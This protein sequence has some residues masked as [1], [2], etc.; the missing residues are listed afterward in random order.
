MKKFRV[1]AAA[2][3]LFSLAFAVSAAAQNNGGGN[4]SGR[5]YYNPNVLKGQLER[6]TKE[7]EEQLPEARKKEIEKQEQE[8]GRPLT[9]E[10]IAK[11]DEDIEMAK[12][13]ALAIKKGMVAAITV[14]FKNEKDMVLKADLKI[15]EE[16]LKAAGIGWLKRKAIKAALSVVPDQKGRYTAKDTV[17]YMVS[18]SG[19][20]VERD[21]L[22]L[23]RDGRFLYGKM[24]EQTPFKLTR[25]K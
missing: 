6:I 11:L 25:T 15:D 12:R 4:L 20:E 16:A 22:T 8:K 9:A 10:E 13:L 17:I 18:G 23:S 1:F 2:V 7:M 21:T 5:V 19:K 24:D 3:V 14:E